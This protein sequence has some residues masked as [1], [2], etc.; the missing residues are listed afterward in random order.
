VYRRYEPS[1]QY[2]A[3]SFPAALWSWRRLPPVAAAAVD[4]SVVSAASVALASMFASM[5]AYRISPWHP[6]ARYP[7]PIL[8]KISKIRVAISYLGGEDYK[9]RKALHDQ[10]GPVVRVGA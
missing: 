6:L 4:V 1:W 5:I 7:G 10:Y 8:H 2:F 3:L 9:S